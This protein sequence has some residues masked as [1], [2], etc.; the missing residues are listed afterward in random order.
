[1]CQGWT[2]RNTAVHNT[3]PWQ[4]LPV[5]AWLGVLIQSM[6]GISLPLHGLLAVY[7]LH[8]ACELLLL[9]QAFTWAHVQACS[10]FFWQSAAKRTVMR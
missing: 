4:F 8:A 5:N 1:M 7:H 3:V 2:P 10:G 6:L 9:F